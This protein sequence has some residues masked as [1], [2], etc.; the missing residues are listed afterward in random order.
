MNLP[1]S[2]LEIDEWLDVTALHLDDEVDDA[3]QHRYLH[4]QGATGQKADTR[5]LPTVGTGMKQVADGHQREDWPVAGHQLA[6]QFGMEGGG[7]LAQH[8]EGG[9]EGGVAE[10]NPAKADKMEGEQHATHTPPAGAAV[11]LGT[12]QPVPKGLVRRQCQTVQTTPYHEIQ[13][14]TVPQPSQQHGHDQIEIGTEPAL[15][16]AAQRDVQVVAQPRRQGDVPTPP[17]LRHTGRLVGGTEVI[18]KLEPQEKG[19]ANG[20]VA[21]AGE[22]AIDLQGVAIHPQQ[23]L[24]AGIEGRIVENALHEV[25]ADV[26]G[27]DGF[28]QESAHEEEDTAAK[29][30]GRDAQGTADL[31]QEVAGTDNGAGHQLRKERHVE[32]IVEQAA[33]GSELTSIDVEGI[34]QRLE[35]E[36]GDAHREEDVEGTERDAP[37]R[38]QPLVEEVGVLEVAEQ[39]EVD[40][41]AQQHPGLPPQCPHGPF[42]TEGDEEVADSDRHQQ[43]EVPAAALV[44]EVV[45]E[46]GDKKQAGGILPPQ[47]TIDTTEPEEQEE[48]HT[49]TENHRLAGIVRQDFPHFT[50]FYRPHTDY[51]I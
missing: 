32:G 9:L 38:A 48:K 6:E 39:S 14:G 10:K 43:E 25:H 31:W 34:T 29:H 51:R 12:V 5:V 28:L 45:G 23:V 1:F 35:G 37:Q 20:H 42:Q 50:D 13:R 36:K 17:E 46:G 47:Q 44:V 16:V 8:D 4:E 21:V 41:E 40:A 18:G 3:D 24:H 30:I 11:V 19:D 7:H 22:V 15:P 26:V 33:Q 49:G 27:N 2:E